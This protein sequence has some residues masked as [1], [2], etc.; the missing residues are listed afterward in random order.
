MTGIAKHIVIVGGG[1]AGWLAAL[2]LAEGAKRSKLDIR[3]TMVES[4]KIP[5]VGVGEGSTAVLRQLF[6]QLGIDELEFLAETEATIKFGIRHRDWRRLGHS[7]D[8][9][10]DDPHQILHAPPGVTS[11]WLN[12]YC[13]STGKSVQEPHL[14][15][16]LLDRGK[17][18]FARKADGGLIPIGP[19]HHGYHFDQ[20]LV[21]KYLRKKAT[22]IAMID[23]QVVGVTKNPESG[24]ITQLLLNE[25]DPIDV[26]FVVDC[27]GFRQALIGKQMGG[28]WISYGDK[29]PV[30]R[31]MPFWVDIKDGEEINPYTLAWA[32]KSGWMWSIPTRSRYG[33]GYVYSDHFTSPDQ[34]QAEIETVLGHKIEPRNDIKINSGRLDKVWM[35]NCLAVG[36]SSS[37]LEPLEATSIH[38]SIVQLMLFAQVHMGINADQIDQHRDTYNQIIAGQVDDFM[39]FINMHYVSERDDSDFWRTVGQEFILPVTKDRLHA[40]SQRLPRKDDFKP[41][42]T[43]LPHVEEQLYY[44]VLDGLGL[45][46]QKLGKAE[47][48]AHPQLRAF[49]RKVTADLIKEYKQGATRAL[50]HR[51]FLESLGS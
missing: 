35:G 44:P 4:S 26:D 36:L 18:P 32:Q 15:S 25:G 43:G 2:I 11:S 8:G 7:Y 22:G 24:D 38:G 19:F 49:A 5:T 46:D 21:A 1:T 12:Q 27:T 30:N 45:L 41:F 28:Q 3:F 37:F 48:A 34:A 10:I 29:L 31:A 50:G 42:P 17:A 39:Q 47:L 14:F 23:A 6:E 9:P 51:E 33:C 13:V 20:A 16:Y 40:W